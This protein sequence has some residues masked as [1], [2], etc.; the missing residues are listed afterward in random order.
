[1]SRLI[2]PLELRESAVLLIKISLK[3]ESRRSVHPFV[4]AECIY[5]SKAV[6]HGTHRT[7][8]SVHSNPTLCME[9]QMI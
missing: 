6:L 3:C 5:R 2:L 8:F 1:M 9:S 4:S 7:V